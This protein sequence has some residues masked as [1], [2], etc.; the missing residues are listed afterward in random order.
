MKRTYVLFLFILTCTGALTLCAQENPK[1][2]ISV[3]ASGKA[4]ARADIAIVFMTVRSTS[5]LAADALDQ[6]NKKVE[7]VKA[8]LTALGYKDEQVKFSGNRF[9]P[10]GGGMYYPAGQRPTG[11]DVYNNI[12]ISIEGP[13][14]NDITQFNKRVSALLD[15]L[16]KAGA[17][18][19]NTPISNISMGGSSVVVFSIKDPAPY[20]NQAMLQALDKARPLADEV[21]RHMK[22]QITGISWSTVTPSG[23]STTG[24]Q[25]SVLD[26]VPYEY[27]SSSID[28]VPVRVRVDVRYTYK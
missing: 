13:E 11:F 26:D 18:T 10:S 14:L 6:N 15:E 24:M 20:E 19:S 22:V 2:T 17:S 4:G 25:P 5:P 28:E 16:S 9:A 8:R 27:F 3:N 23:R 7:D 12:Y 1:P 21:A